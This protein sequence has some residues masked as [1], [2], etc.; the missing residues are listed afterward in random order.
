MWQKNMVHAVRG[1]TRKQIFDLEW[2]KNPECRRL[3]INKG[4]KSSPET[5]GYYV[6]HDENGVCLR[7]GCFDNDNNLKFVPYEKVFTIHQQNVKVYD[8][9]ELLC[10]GAGSAEEVRQ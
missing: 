8:Y 1:M 4:W 10:Q 9:F 6:R 3:F 2:E 5:R 7:A